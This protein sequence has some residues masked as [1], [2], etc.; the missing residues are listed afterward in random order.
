MRLKK[1]ML[2]LMV[3]IV[4]GLPATGVGQ[5]T[6]QPAGQPQTGQSGQQNQPLAPVS[7][8]E[9]SQIPQQEGPP[10]AED[11]RS[12]GGAEGAS[13]GPSGL[14]RGYFIP[15]FQ[16]SEMADSNATIVGGN[17]GWETTELLVGRLDFKRVGR[18]AQAT[19]E[20]RGGATIYNRNSDLNYTMHEF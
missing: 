1:E 7:A 5:Q 20:Y 11:P 15:S 12:F 3:A 16:I 19:A 18:R 8:E 9:P 17:R 4:L 13:L 2:A 14:L 10:P 6:A